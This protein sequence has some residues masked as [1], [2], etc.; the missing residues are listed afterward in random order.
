MLEISEA[1]VGEARAAQ[2]AGYIGQ[3]GE[4]VVQHVGALCVH[5]QLAV[6]V[7]SCVVLVVNAIRLSSFIT[8]A[9]SS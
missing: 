4:V 8:G 3:R 1:F 9:T 2:R 5:V 7:T 6:A